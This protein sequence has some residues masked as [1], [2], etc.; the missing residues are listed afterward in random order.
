M[1]SIGW[2]VKLQRSK[3][4]SVPLEA[5]RFSFI[6]DIFNRYITDVQG[7]TQAELKSLPFANYCRQ[8]SACLSSVSISDP[9][10]EGCIILMENTFWRSTIRSPSAVFTGAPGTVAKFVAKS[11][12][13][14]EMQKKYS[15]SSP[16]SWFYPYYHHLLELFLL[17]PSSYLEEIDIN[18]LCN[19]NL[20][21]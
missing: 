17:F 11:C 1:K 14:S 16:Q 20:L 9:P 10:S 21:S 7:R 8:Q 4:W 3:S 2:A 13:S 19:N 5:Q 6:D 18:M 15:K 12:F